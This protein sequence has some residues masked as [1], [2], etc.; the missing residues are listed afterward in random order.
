MHRLTAGETVLENG[1]FRTDWIHDPPIGSQTTFWG[2]HV[3]F[4]FNY[5]SPSKTRQNLSHLHSQWELEK[6]EEVWQPD[7]SRRLLLC[8]MTFKILTLHSA[9]HN[10]RNKMKNIK[11]KSFDLFQLLY[12]RNK[13]LE[14]GEWGLFSRKNA[15]HWRIK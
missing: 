1:S 10:K 9:R 6:L 15:I 5:L 4:N 13:V 2:C 11:R 3:D 14:F 8:E 12:P 7:I